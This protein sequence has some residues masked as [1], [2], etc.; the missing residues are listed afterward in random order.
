MSTESITAELDHQHRVLAALADQPLRPHYLSDLHEKTALPWSELSTLLGRMKDTGWII[1]DWQEHPEN[2]RLPHQPRYGLS[3][4]GI[5]I[6]NHR[7]AA[8]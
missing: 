1:A 7:Q 4:R 8:A 3:A 2:L 5:D 6:W